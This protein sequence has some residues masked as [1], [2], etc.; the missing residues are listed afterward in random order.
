VPG[1]SDKRNSILL[2]NGKPRSGYSQLRRRPYTSQR[3]SHLSYDG[4]QESI[5][6]GSTA[7]FKVAALKLVH[8]EMPPGDYCYRIERWRFEGLSTRERLAYGVLPLSGGTALPADDA[9]V[10]VQDLLRHGEDWDYVDCDREQLV[11]THKNLEEELSNRFVESVEDFE[12]ENETMYH[13]KVQRIKSF[14]ARRIQQHEQRIRTLS[15]SRGDP[16]AIRLAQGLR[17]TAIQNKQTRLDQLGVKKQTVPKQDEVA[18]G[19]FRVLS[20][21]Q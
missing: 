15:E 8:P 21:V 9:E 11:N 17:D 19:V 7:F 18:V 16:R 5:A 14:Y 3:T 1:H 13:M 2:S 4:S 20:T 12:A 10:I 6:T